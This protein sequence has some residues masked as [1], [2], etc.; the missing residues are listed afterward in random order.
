MLRSSSA[1]RTTLADAALSHTSP[2]LQRAEKGRWNK[3]PQHRTRVV[4]MKHSKNMI[5]GPIAV[6]ILQ[7]HDSSGP[8]RPDI[9]RHFSTRGIETA[10]GR[11]LG[12]AFEADQRTRPPAFRAPM[13]Q[14]TQAPVHHARWLGTHLAWR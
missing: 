2:T 9:A 11:G 4:S 8:V 14:G 10:Q 6:F 13:Q 3:Q 5:C 12:H 7:Q 1:A